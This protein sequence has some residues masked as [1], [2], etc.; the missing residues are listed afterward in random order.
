MQFATNGPHPTRISDHVSSTARQS[1]QVPADAWPELF[2]PVRHREWNACPHGVML[3][4]GA[5]CAT[6]QSVALVMHGF[7]APKN[8]GRMEGGRRGTG[9]SP[10]AYRAQVRRHFL[11][12]RSS[13]FLFKWRV[14]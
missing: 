9:L 7:H 1:G 4:M 2:H 5:S 8:C 12:L 14:V 3:S 11:C 6:S 10:D 13:L